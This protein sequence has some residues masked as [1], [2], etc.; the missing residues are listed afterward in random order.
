MPEYAQQPSVSCR[1][2]GSGFPYNISYWEGS[3]AVW[4]SLTCSF[5][6]SIFRLPSFPCSKPG[7][8]KIC[9]TGK[10][11]HKR[12]KFRMVIILKIF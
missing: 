12:H 1:G 3:M 9:D 6:L 2:E 5:N 8:D 10:A 11:K 7:T 4:F